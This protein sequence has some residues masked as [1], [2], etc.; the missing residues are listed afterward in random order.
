M[1]LPEASKRVANPY[2]TPGTDVGDMRLPTAVICHCDGCRQAMGSLGAYGFTSDMATL[3]L[4]ILPKAT[5]P[6]RESHMDDEKR[7][8]YVPAASLMDDP[9]EVNLDEL[10]L[11][12]YESSPKRDRW[13]C[14][15]CGTQ[16][17]VAASKD[18]I[19]P[20]W[21]WPRVVNVWAGTTDRDL[22]ENDCKYEFFKVQCFL[23]TNREFT[24]HFYS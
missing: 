24:S 12:R 16:I 22:L 17:A 8:S 20:E 19:P 18:T 1:S 2:H 7:P 6:D 13:F 10:W 21:G 3:E 14:G 23:P 5:I 15:R 9:E 11:M 4:S